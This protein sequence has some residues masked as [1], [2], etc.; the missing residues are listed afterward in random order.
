[1][2]GG[3]DSSVAAAL[4]REQ[5][6]EVI[7]LHMLLSEPSAGLERAREAAAR[8]D[9]PLVVV[10][11]R[12]EFRERV[13]EPFIASYRSGRTPNPCLTCNPRIKFGALLEH[14]RSLDAARLATGHYAR[15]GRSA[16]GAT[17]L[18]GADTAK[19]QSYFLALLPRERLGHALF[20]LGEMTKSEVRRLAEGYRFW[21]ELPEESQEVC[22]LEG[23]DY[24]SLLPEGE[25]GDI[26]GLDGRVLGRHQGLW[27][28]TIGQRRGLGVAAAE[29][30]YVRALDIEANRVVVAAAGEAPFRRMTVG[31]INWLSEPTRK[32]FRCFVRTRYRQTDQ[33]CLAGPDADGSLR[34]EFD[35]PQQALSAGQGAVF[36]EGE[37]VLAGGII[38][39]AW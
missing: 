5:G 36:Y 33:A 29:P 10:D 19:D 32:P 18:R 3:V 17:L 23:A 35:E 30:L 24:R 27:R 8:L 2:S 14:A 15:T 28:Y 25:P 4:C 20:P 13:V 6:L 22:F 16:G 34:V 37:R 12:A 39:Q 31:G 21:A 11:L 1:M 7:G 26:V 9:I 38:E